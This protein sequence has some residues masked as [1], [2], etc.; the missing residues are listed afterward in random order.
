MVNYETRSDIHLARHV[1]RS[2][3]A[4]SEQSID[5]TSPVSFALAELHKRAGE[6]LASERNLISAKGAPIISRPSDV[7]DLV[8]GVTGLWINQV[9]QGIRLLLRM[10]PGGLWPWDLWTINNFGRT[11]AGGG[12]PYCSRPSF[13]RSYVT[14]S[15]RTRTLIEC[16]SCE[17]V[18]DQPEPNCAP[19][20]L[21]RCPERFSVPGTIEAILTVDNSNG[22]SSCY[23]AAALAVANTGHGVVSI[24]DV[25]AVEVPGG[26]R[27]DVSLRL[28]ASGPR[29]FRTGMASA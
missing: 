17:I 12:C 22:K 20:L 24:P 6:V 7:K 21:L 27:L 25:V 2:A 28:S 8:A 1:T 23:G 15:G 11:Q 26:G 13:F 14:P 19:L 18:A 16:P 10:A 5:W 4:I 9:S 3:K 29:R